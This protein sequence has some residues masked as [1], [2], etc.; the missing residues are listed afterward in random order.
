MFVAYIFRGAVALS[1]SQVIYLLAREQEE[2]EK[3]KREKPK[4]V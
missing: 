3:N 4:H 2:K 1:S